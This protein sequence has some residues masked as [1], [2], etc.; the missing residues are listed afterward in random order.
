MNAQLSMEQLYCI[1]SSAL[2]E[3]WNPDN[4][5]LPKDVSQLIWS[6]VD[7]L[8]AQQRIIS[9]RE[10]YDEIKD[11]L[12]DGF[13]QW[14]RVHRDIF[15]EL[16]SEQ[17]KLGKAIVNKYPLLTDGG[18]NHADPFVVS[19]AKAHG[20]TVIGCEK[21]VTTTHSQ[22]RPKI[23]SLCHEHAVEYVTIKDFCM[24][25]RLSFRLA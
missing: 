19:V 18:R 24:K 3:L 20:A 13:R 4:W 21:P 8:V 16:D 5:Q 22:I 14:M 12:N 15:L 11:D 7:T 23:P 2:I 1:D 9:S 10:V 17:I 25:E 6:H